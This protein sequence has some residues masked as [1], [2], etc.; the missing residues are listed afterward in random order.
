MA[1]GALR[2]ASIAADQADR[3]NSASIVVDP[4]PLFELSPWLYMQFM[5]PLGMT[6]ALP[7]QSDR[8]QDGKKRHTSG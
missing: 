4:N 2:P 8:C 6:C 1:G 7:L 5:E 3:R